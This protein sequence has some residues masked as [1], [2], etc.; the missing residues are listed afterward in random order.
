M[1]SIR[2]GVIGAG[3]IGRV[4]AEN[5]AYRLPGAELAVVADPVAAAAEACAQ[6]LKVSNWKTDYREVL[7]DPT[8]KAVV[9]ASSTDT[10]AQ[11]IEEAA[12]AGKD[13]FCEKPIDLDLARVDR[14]LTAVDRAGVRL[15]IGFN[16]RFDPSFAKAK[17]LIAEGGIGKPHMIK[18]TS[19]DPQPASIEYLAVSGGIFTD[20][21]IH[22]FD[23]VRWLM[24][25]EVVE[26]FAMGAVLIDPAIG[27]LNDVDT[28]MISLRYA[29]GA[30]GNIDNS[31]KAV[32]GYD[33]RVEVFGSE[34]TIAI[35]NVAPTSVAHTTPKGISGET[36][37][38]WFIE[39]F[40]QAYMNE[41]REF[42]ASIQEDRA[43]SVTGADGRA[44]LVM[45]QAAWRSLREGRAVRLDTAAAPVS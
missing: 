28:A 35:G 21:T 42:V 10:H 25:E 4:H 18:V 2:F 20:M 33:V 1:S 43:P 14:A 32:Y 23:V 38:H 44:P 40:E 24:G 3:R 34:G 39:R 13:I 26:L 30:L 37:M 9:I 36:P 31:R 7:A 15:Q 22:D 29:S 5:L 12:A 8:I 6:Q 41:M 45:A 27:E 11:I 16:R 19:R 17:R